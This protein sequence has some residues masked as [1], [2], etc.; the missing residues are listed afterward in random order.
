METDKDITVSRGN[1][2]GR[3][4]EL[5]AEVL[6]YLRELEASGVISTAIGPDGRMKYYAG[7][8]R[9]LS[10]SRKGNVT[11]LANAARKRREGRS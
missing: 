7:F 9:K 8:R 4:D 11:S 2:L 1:S 10:N 3:D 6:R 5:R